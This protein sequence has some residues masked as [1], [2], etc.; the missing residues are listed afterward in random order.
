[1]SSTFLVVGAAGQ[2]GTELVLSLRQIYGNDKVIASDIR[3]HAPE[4]LLAG[5]YEQIDV[6]D[7]KRLLEVVQKHKVKEIYH[8]AALLSATA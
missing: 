2:I 7:G 1:M 4:A 8:L 5:P 6:L 3:P